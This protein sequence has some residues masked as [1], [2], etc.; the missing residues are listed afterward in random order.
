MKVKGVELGDE[1]AV[2]GSKENLEIHHI[3]PIS[4]GGTNEIENL[5]IL[6]RKCNHKIRDNI[7]PIVEK[8]FRVTQ[9]GGDGTRG[10]LRGDVIKVSEGTKKGLDKLKIHPR[11]TYDDVI[12][13]LVEEEKR[14]EN[15]I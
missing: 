12:S 7:V 6:C 8:Q 9:F 10:N 4:K 1:C 13:R 15:N 14:E 3:V 2:C 11:E 5:A